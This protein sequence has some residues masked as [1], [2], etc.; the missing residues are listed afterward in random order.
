MGRG[1][2]TSLPRIFLDSGVFLEGLLS[3]WG[4]SRATLILC[5]R[6]VCR[7]ILAEY[8]RGEVGDNLRELLARDPR[9]ATEA[10]DA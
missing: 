8:V 4:A 10:L 6:G 2:P 7:I 5:R 3:P 1:N 9:V